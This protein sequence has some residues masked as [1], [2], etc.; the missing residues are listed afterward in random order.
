MPGLP[1]RP[2][3]Q[4][5]QGRQTVRR[6]D[7][8]GCI[9]RSDRLALQRAHRQLG[10]GRVDHERALAPV[11]GELAGVG[12]HL[13]ARRDEVAVQLGDLLAY[14]RT[15]IIGDLPDPPDSRPPWAWA[16]SL[17][18]SWS[19]KRFP[20]HRPTGPVPAFNT[21]SQGPPKTGEE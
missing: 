18:A 1:Q 20:P 4:A 6:G 3:V 2:I 11:A 21:V 8:E 16:F 15:E 12:R 9:G 10:L 14:G 5:A 13:A 19:R 17:P 7:L